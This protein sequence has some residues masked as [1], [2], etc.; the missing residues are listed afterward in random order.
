MWGHDARRSGYSSETLSKNLHLQWV[1]ELPEPR[2]AWGDDQD[3]LR[4]DHHYE[5]VL[6]DGRVFVPSMVSDRLT[7]YDAATGKE[8]WRFYAGGPLRFAAAAWKRRVYFSSD[9]GYLYC[10]GAA[11]GTL[12]W[13]FRG[14]PAE[15]LILGNGRLIST[16]PAR[17]APVVQDG[18]VYF[19]ASIWPCMGVFIHALDARTGER[20]WTNSGSGAKLTVQQHNSPAF[21]GIAPQ[22]YLAVTGNRLVVAGG[23]TV[24]AVFDRQNGALVHF[25]VSSRSM[26]SKGGG[27]Y[28]VVAGDRFF[29]NGGEVYRL[30][31][32]A[33]VGSVN[34]R[35]HSGDA[36]VGCDA[37]GLCAF[38]PGWK[39]IE[40]KDRRGRTRKV[41]I[42]SKLWSEPLDT[43]IEEVFIQ[44]GERVYCRG[45]HGLILAVDL[46]RGE[47]SPEITWKA[48]LPEEARSMI[49]GDGKLL[50]STV[51]GRI[52]CFGKTPTAARLPE[53]KMV[54]LID[55][56]A[57]W[58]FL[59]DGADPGSEWFTK[60]FDD[61]G[62]RAGPAPLGYGED[63]LGTTLSFGSDPAR[64]PLTCYF[65]REF[66]VPE[67]ARLESVELRVLVDDGA[68]IYLNGREIAR[69]FL[70]GGE[71]RPDTRA[72]NGTDEKTYYRIAVPDAV[73]EPGTNLLA[74]EVHQRQP[75]SSDVLFDL[76]LRAP[77]AAPRPDWDEKED[78]W[79]RRAR[80]ILEL[81]G[82]REGY[83]LALGLGTGRLAVELARQSSL[84]VIVL[85]PDKAKAD[86]F[87]R[88]ADE[89]GIYGKRIALV[90]AAHAD[91]D[92]PAYA[93]ELIVSEEPEAAGLRRGR[94]F[95]EQIFHC[96]RPFSG[97]AYFR[98]SGAAGAAFAEAADTAKL[99]NGSWSRRGG[100][101]MLKRTEP[102]TGSA[103]WTHQYADAANTVVSEDSVVKAP[104]ALL[105]FGG[106]S[107]ADVLPRHGHGPAPHVVSG[108]LFIEGRDML[109][110][111]D[112]YTGRLLWQ[113]QLPDVGEYYDYTSHQPGANAIGSNYVSL[114]DG[115]YILFRDRCLRLDPA[116]GKTLS[117]FVLPESLGGRE[118]RRW[119]FLAARDDLLV[120][121]AWPVDFSSHEFDEQ[122]VSGFEGNRL[123]FE[124]SIV[125]GWS[126]FEPIPYETARELYLSGTPAEE[127]FR[128]D[129]DVPAEES[130]VADDRQGDQRETQTQRGGG[131]QGRQRRGW[132]RFLISEQ[133]WRKH[134]EAEHRAYLLANLN[135]LLLEDDMASKIPDRTY[136][137]RKAEGLRKKLTRYLRKPGAKPNDPD[138]LAIK[139]EIFQRCYRLPAYEK[140]TPGKFGSSARTG[141]RILLAL[142]RDTGEPIWEHRAEHQFRHSA[143]VVGGGSVYCLDRMPAQEA[144]Y[145]RRRG[146]PVN[147]GASVTGLDARTGRIRW[148]N[149]ERVFGT[150]LCYSEEHDVLIQAGARGP[151]RTRD[152]PGRGIVAYRGAT[153]KILWRS[154]EGYSGPCL[155]LGRRIITQ[156]YQK[157]GLALDLLSG[158]RIR[159][160]HPLSGAPVDWGYTRKYGCNTAIGSPNLLT[161]R[162][163]AAGY[164]DLLAD[165]G[166]SNLGGVRSGCTSNLIPAGGILNAPDYTRTCTC[167][168]QN[169]ASAAF[170]HSP[171]AQSWSFSPYAHDKRAVKKVGLNLGAP[172]DRLGPDGTLWLDLPSDGGESPDIPVE[173]QPEAGDFEFPRHHESWV[174]GELPW[175]TAS[176]L[177][178]AGEIVL[179]LAPR[180]EAA[181]KSRAQKTS[182][183]PSVNGD[184]K[185][186]T[187]RLFFAELED[188]EPG[189]RTFDVEVEGEKIEDLDIVALAGRPR[190][191]LVREFRGIQV[192]DKLRIRLLSSE[193]REPLL[194]GIQVLGEW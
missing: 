115:V 49:A 35:V 29:L 90:A 1:L 72:L 104:L 138:A 191:T 184:P 87:R 135:K 32:G 24:P 147:E 132:G 20:I 53:S 26:G 75:N 33:F 159:R 149:G 96:L 60:S 144:S 158:E 106:P 68:A 28:D 30:Q 152:E 38:E 123:R 174:S 21:A 139:R 19:A 176:A 18:T 136:S 76:E 173:L 50:V 36:L 127:E 100:Y 78:V 181:A 129:D 61:E 14:A 46:P 83:C 7:C 67:S 112:I 133:E 169:Q 89:I 120:A 94:P 148:T 42:V 125:R 80:E 187:V 56:G 101:V 59:E 91:L 142:D 11:S 45:K 193:N 128:D 4:F 88:R 111:T 178:G 27:G 57:S 182:V 156:G 37:K 143:I 31:N 63:G 66:E 162:S 3:K 43:K 168:Y 186:Y 55:R 163:A 92:L 140:N 95:V 113:R 134:S 167:S 107:N 99:D 151:D 114:R 160:P 23:R 141:S 9:D 122:S 85:E 73:L 145:Y 189:E 71:L 175:V 183:G 39:E 121:G 2:P 65:R 5:P 54:R 157:P 16:W 108:R 171:T 40:R 48:Q 194:S 58:K 137:W 110:A 118:K 10:L 17:G 154:N 74:A 126:D 179:D 153:G 177:R 13:R 69:L 52:Y 64:K 164:Y 124:V 79:M 170:I 188:L 161:F 51:A 12:L 8:I 44:C 102:P 82:A 131:R 98:L 165:C 166:T 81:S 146:K 180:H 119:G 103:D 117:T 116:S 150:W 25:K 6:L 93:A 77:R 185:P 41:T 34:A 62:W 192:R 86:A 109:R 22:G 155:L 84:H 47:T 130:E 105:W 172:G 190:R 97:S 15:R 70:P